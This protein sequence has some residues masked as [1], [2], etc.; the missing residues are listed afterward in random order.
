MAVI[1]SVPSASY[2]ANRWQFTSGNLT[3]TWATA[4]LTLT[5]ESWPDVGGNLLSIG[6]E[7]SVDAGQSWS[8]LASATAVGG[9]LTYPPTHPRAGQDITVFAMRVLL[10]GVGVVTRRVRGFIENAASLQ[11][12]VTLEAV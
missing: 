5:R 11:T 8:F 12:A 2:P 10:P 3:T 1:A 4:T 7:Y 6:L 9:T